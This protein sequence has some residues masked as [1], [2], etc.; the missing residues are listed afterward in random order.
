[1]EGGGEYEQL[2]KR[3]EKLEK[4]NKK[5][6]YKK[7]L[8][9]RYLISCLVLNHDVE[10]EPYEDG[11]HHMIICNDCGC[12]NFEFHNMHKNSENNAECIICK[13]VRQ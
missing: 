5:L 11:M 1:M 7:Q 9:C 6:K 4:E 3:I 8:N 13:S 10:Y 2:I 12:I